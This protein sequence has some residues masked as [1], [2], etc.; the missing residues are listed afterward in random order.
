MRTC[1]HG[2]R[3]PEPK[4]LTLNPNPNIYAEGQ[5]STHIVQQ[6]EWSKELQRKSTHEVGKPQTAPTRVE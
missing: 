2:T 6:I 3:N 4:P 1:H 5:I